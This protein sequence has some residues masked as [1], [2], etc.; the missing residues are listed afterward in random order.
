MSTKNIKAVENGAARVLSYDRSTGLPVF[1]NLNHPL[2]SRSSQRTEL[3]SPGSLSQKTTNLPSLK[4]NEEI[5]QQ[6]PNA[7]NSQIT[8]LQVRRRVAASP[9]SRNKYQ[10]A[11][12]KLF[13]KRVSTSCHH[14]GQLTQSACLAQVT[15]PHC[16]RILTSR[17][18]K[19]IL[20]CG[21]AR[22]QRPSTN[23]SSLKP[24]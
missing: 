11:I 15:C 3:I 20:S 4:R 17:A 14:E 18:E 2:E 19:H 16:Q 24:I 5:E 13:P 12:N 9:A 6:A 23:K 10:S 8:D 21:E 22:M 1:R 7:K